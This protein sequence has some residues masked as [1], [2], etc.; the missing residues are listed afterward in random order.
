MCRKKI[1]GSIF[2]VVNK[3]RETEKVSLTLNVSELILENPKRCEILKLYMIIVYHQESKESRRFK[4]RGL[5][6][7]APKNFVKKDFLQTFF[8]S[9]CNNNVVSTF[10]KGVVVNLNK[11]IQKFFVYDFK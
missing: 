7:S 8:W 2:K 5:D 1:S 11:K 6:I 10:D 9:I 4:R 3:E